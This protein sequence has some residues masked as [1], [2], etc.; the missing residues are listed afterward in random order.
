[1]TNQIRATRGADL[2]VVYAGGVMSNRRIRPYLAEAV[3]GRV[4]FAPPAF[5]ADNAAGVAL[6]TA[7]LHEKA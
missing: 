3:G 5:S 2:A 6:L 7:L 4:Y 1:M